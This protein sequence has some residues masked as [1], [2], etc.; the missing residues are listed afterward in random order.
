MAVG[1]WTPLFG[2]ISF[3]FR[4]MISATKQLHAFSVDVPISDVFFSRAFRCRFFYHFL[5]SLPGS[6]TLD[7]FR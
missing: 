6:N 1:G 2:V 7:F 5:L 3:F 4:A